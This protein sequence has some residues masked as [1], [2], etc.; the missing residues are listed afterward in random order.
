MGARRR[1]AVMADHPGWR[2]DGQGRLRRLLRSPD[3]VWLAVATPSSGGGHEIE[4]ELVDGRPGAA[5][6]VDVVDPATLTETGSRL[7]EVLLARGPVTR[8]RSSDLWD[9]L[10]GAVFRCTMPAEQARGLYRDAAIGLGECYGTRLGRE[11]LFP[12]PAQVLDLSDDVFDVYGLALVRD[13]LRTAASTVRA[14]RSG[15][16][17]L[18]WD[19]LY[20]CLAQLPRDGSLIAG[21]AVAD[22]SGDFR[23]VVSSDFLVRNRVHRLEPASSWPQDALRF[24]PRWQAMTG[25]QRSDWTLLILADPVRH[26]T[27]P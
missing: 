25:I 1:P 19:V 12:E 26:A 8:A 22:L 5:P 20:T 21:A 17:R 16:Q 7:R 9:A 6:R 10:V 2:R 14:L 4:V 15:W 3:A 11:Q 13:R 24:S 23:F 18:S 27:D